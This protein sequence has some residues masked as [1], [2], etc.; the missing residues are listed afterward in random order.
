MCKSNLKLM[1][2]LSAWSPEIFLTEAD[3]KTAVP[4]LNNALRTF[5]D[6]G[7]FSSN[8]SLMT[9][10]KFE[11]GRALSSLVQI[12]ANLDV[13]SEGCRSTRCFRTKSSRMGATTRRSTSARGCRE[14]ATST[15]QP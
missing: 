3:I 11:S 10:F 5:V 1:R 8:R 6:A 15:T 14:P 2:E 12:Y 7:S 13:R 9:K 4:L